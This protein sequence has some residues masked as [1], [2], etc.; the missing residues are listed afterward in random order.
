MPDPDIA[1][2]LAEDIAAGRFDEAAVEKLNAAL[3]LLADRAV[4][5]ARALEHGPLGRLRRL[6]GR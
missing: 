4:A 6:V 1:A 5:E 3:R 2:I